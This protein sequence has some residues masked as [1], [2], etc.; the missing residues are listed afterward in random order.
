MERSWLLKMRNEA[1]TG[2]RM[3]GRST[4]TAATHECLISGRD[5]GSLNQSNTNISVALWHLPSRANNFNLNNEWTFTIIKMKYLNVSYSRADIGHV[6]S[7]FKTLQYGDFCF[8]VGFF[9]VF[10]CVGWTCQVT[11]R[12][13][14]FQHCVYEPHAYENIMV[15]IAG[16]GC[17][18][19]AYLTWY[20]LLIL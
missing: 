16:S 4:T 12:L 8:G 3:E 15:S 14:W 7:A 19:W 5:N 13:Q 20:K 10:A 17:A 11:C 6:Y 9:P 1:A 2:D 18:W